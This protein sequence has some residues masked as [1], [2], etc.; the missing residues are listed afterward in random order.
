MARV[1]TMEDVNKILT[2]HREGKTPGAIA[3]EVKVKPNVVSRV[4]N[5]GWRPT[6]RKPIRISKSTSRAYYID[7]KD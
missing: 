7:R 6:G 1:T 3:K 2:L 4:L 5:E